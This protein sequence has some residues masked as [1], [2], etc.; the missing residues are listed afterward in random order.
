VPTGCGEER[1][2]IDLIRDGGADSEREQLVR[3]AV[4]RKLPGQA[5]NVAVFRRSPRSISMIGG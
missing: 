1:S 5:R 4:W 2:I 3:D